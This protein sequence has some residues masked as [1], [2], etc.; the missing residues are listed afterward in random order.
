MNAMIRRVFALFVILS[1]LIPMGASASVVT[2]D[3]HVI[4]HP[5]LLEEFDFPENWSENALRFCVGN[6]ILK[7][8]T[9]GLAPQDH[10]TRAET[11]AILVRLLGVSARSGDLSRFVDVSADSWY[12]PE[13]AAAVEHGILT[14][15]SSN[16][17]EPN[18]SVT[19]EQVFTMISRAFGLYAKDPEGWNG[20]SDSDACSGYSKNA[21]SALCERGIVSGYPD[22]TLRPKALITRAE[23]AQLIYALFTCICDEPAHLPASGR[24]L[25]RGTGPI[26][27]N[28]TLD[29]SLTVAGEGDAMELAGVNIQ[30]ALTIRRRPGS[31]VAL[32]NCQTEELILS[33]KNLTVNLIG[34]VDRCVVN[35]DN[36]TLTGSGSVDRVLMIGSDC[37]IQILVERVLQPGELDPADALEIV[38]TLVVWDTVTEDTYL[39]SSSDL[40]GRIVALPAGTK[41]DHYYYREGNRGAS[42]YTE[43]GRFGW[44][45]INC[46]S[47]PEEYE[48][49]EPYSQ[50]IMEAFV[51]EKGYTSSTRYLIWVSLKTQTVN[52]FEGSKGEW[53][54]I[55]SMPCASGKNS[56]PTARGEFA[57]KNKVWEWDFGSYKVRNVTVFY[58]GYAFHSRIYNRSY[59]VMLDDAIGYPASDGC[60]R[61]LDE[62]CR[63]IIDEMPYNTRVV[64]Y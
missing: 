59:S 15:T 29:G 19:R 60:L 14:G 51:N 6:E 13:V 18:A 58:G 46:I 33:G 56:T 52:V 43:N 8:K 32:T 30:G 17:M 37:D 1:L 5:E 42:V 23:L 34:S 27:E 36:M 49:H 16:T 38:E 39:Y 63:Y 44:V 24:V 50:E 48:I 57:I 53:H 47:I 26:P 28:Y 45:D 20:F 10:T 61:M 22:G 62:D 41:L 9:D 4:N 40:T 2:G 64:V 25:Y 11:A 35:G 54:L 21:I 3:G 7:G 31:S 12:Y 55:R